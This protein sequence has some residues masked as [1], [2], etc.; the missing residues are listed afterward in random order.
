MGIEP[1]LTSVLLGVIAFLTACL[2]GV[3]GWVGRRIFLQ[4]DAI[5]ALLR[6]AE[7]EI[8]QRINDHE[9][10]IT[11]V[12]VRCEVP[13]VTLSRQSAQPITDADRAG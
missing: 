6:S 13:R 5:K 12:E 10:R 2:V 7:T 11:R 1:Q 3:V 4:M 8:H 9:T